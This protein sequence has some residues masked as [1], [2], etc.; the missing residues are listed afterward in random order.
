[1]AKEQDGKEHVAIE[2][3]EKDSQRTK[4]VGD[5]G[6]LVSI[7]IVILLVTAIVSGGGAFYATRTAMENRIAA[8]ENEIQI[9]AP[10]SRYVRLSSLYKQIADLKVLEDEMERIESALDSW[11]IPELTF[12]HGRPPGVP[13]FVEIP[14]SLEWLDKSKISDKT[15]LRALEDRVINKII[16]NPQFGSIRDYDLVANLHQVS[17][18]LSSYNESIASIGIA[19]MPS[20]P[21]P[22][23]VAPEIPQGASR[24][25]VESF[26][27]E[28]QIRVATLKGLVTGLKSRI[29]SARTEIERV[30]PTSTA[31]PNSRMDSDN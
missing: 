2:N 12:Q 10:V 17:L 8:L 5:G 27:S 6:K 16:L 24:K 21:Q 18:N 25:D 31:T 22:P 7:E 9:S 1:M 19:L 15:A 30:I 29:T 20:M 4:H 28:A 26:F 23:H 13:S 11:K 14:E 3:T